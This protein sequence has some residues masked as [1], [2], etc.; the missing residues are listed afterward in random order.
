MPEHPSHPRFWDSRYES[1]RTPWETPGLPP[2][3]RRFLDQPRAPA[4]VLVPGCGSGGEL[5]AFAAA[6]LDVTAI[7]FSP[8]A[9]QLARARSTPALAERIVLGDFF[10]H[11]FAPASFDLVYE[12]TFFC[13][14]LPAQRAACLARLA[15]LLAPGGVLF[16]YF[17]LGEE[18]GGPPFALHAADHDRLF[19][20]HFELIN[21]EP[22][23]DPHPL[24]GP[25]ER[26]REYRRRAPA[27]PH[28]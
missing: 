17:Y 4:R 18:F 7:D 16:G 8:A 2:R 19:P 23:A 3:L 13:A 5:D 25:G 24:F 20:P 15:A 14:L 21:D 11:P 10:A 22:V 27:A 12:R 6:G 26:W 28:H 1:G 9:I